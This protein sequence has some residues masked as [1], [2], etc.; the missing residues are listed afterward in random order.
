MQLS[1]TV[2]LIIEYFDSVSIVETEESATMITDRNRRWKDRKEKIK[3]EESSSKERR[4]Q[5]LKLQW[6][7]APMRRVGFVWRPD[8]RWRCCFPVALNILFIP[9]DTTFRI[10]TKLKPEIEAIIRQFY[11]VARL[12]GSRRENVFTIGGPGWMRSLVS[13]FKL[14]FRRSLVGLRVVR[15]RFRRKGEGG[16]YLETTR[17]YKIIIFLNTCGF[18][19]KERV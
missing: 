7:R 14:N 9:Y 12:P 18:S 3:K 6:N 19:L 2:C 8:H 1:V 15:L 11:S 16:V 5:V 13:E 10:W 17:M 4:L